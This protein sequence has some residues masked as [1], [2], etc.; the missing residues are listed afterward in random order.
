M[1]IGIFESEQ[2]FTI[3]D[4]SEILK[5]WS[6]RDIN[7]IPV[8][9]ADNYRYFTSAIVESIEIKFNGDIRYIS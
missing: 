1:K 5:I 3:D 7:D 9:M 4:I 6:Y 8:I 2:A